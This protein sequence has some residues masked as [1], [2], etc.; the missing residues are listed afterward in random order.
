MNAQTAKNREKLLSGLQNLNQFFIST[1]TKKRAWKTGG[2]KQRFL[3]SSAVINSKL[4]TYN[5]L[6]FLLKSSTAL[7]QWNAAAKQQK[8]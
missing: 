1:P 3:G 8:G 4:T 6:I 5:K 7:L 2:T